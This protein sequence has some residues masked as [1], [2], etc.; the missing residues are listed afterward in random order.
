MGFGVW[1]LGFWTKFRLQSAREGFGDD[2][3]TRG[4]LVMLGIMTAAK[5]G[6]ALSVWTRVLR[7]VILHNGGWLILYCK[8]VYRRRCRASCSDVL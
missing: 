6:T 1:H 2:V 4:S 3:V 5:S 7:R 8:T